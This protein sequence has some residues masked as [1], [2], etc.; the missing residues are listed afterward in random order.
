M[1]QDAESKRSDS[2]S[3]HLKSHSIPRKPILVLWQ[4]SNRTLF[5]TLGFALFVLVGLLCMLAAD[6]IP[7]NVR[8][9]HAVD[10]LAD[11]FVY[12]GA[13]V[14]LLKG[15]AYLRRKSN[16]VQRAISA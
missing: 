5:L 11:E 15:P 9:P 2:A 7:V 14:M 1:W 8:L 10:I 3:T 16:A 12:P 6:W 4:E 13:L